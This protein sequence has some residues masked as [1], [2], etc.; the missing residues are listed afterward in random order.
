MLPNTEPVA[1][2]E[3]APAKVI[4]IVEDD[5]ANAEVLMHVFLQE[6]RYFVYVAPDAVAALQCISQ[7]NPDLFI[8]DY[9]LPRMTG[10][11]LYDCLHAHSRFNQT[12]ALIL[13]ACLE[14]YQEAIES[15]KLLALAKPF[16][17]DELLSLIA[18]V[19]DHSLTSQQ[20]VAQAL[21]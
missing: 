18:K 3:A 14:D 6:T 7:I 2:T 1:V 19:F 20:P 15:R 11:E 13:S 17:V 5:E 10:I 16:D 8:L 9:C 21:S 4:L 12:P